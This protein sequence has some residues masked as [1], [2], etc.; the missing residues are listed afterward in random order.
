MIM[1]PTVRSLTDEIFN[2][3]RIN[4]NFNGPPEMC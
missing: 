2:N 3:V 1:L 4:K